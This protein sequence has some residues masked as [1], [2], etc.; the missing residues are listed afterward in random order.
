MTEL[1]PL[2]IVNSIYKGVDPIKVYVVYKGEYKDDD[3]PCKFCGKPLEF[4]GNMNGWVMACSG[5]DW[6][7]GKLVN[8]VGRKMADD[9]YSESRIQFSDADQVAKCGYRCTIL[10]L[11]QELEATKKELVHLSLE[12][13]NAIGNQK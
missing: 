13:L 10:R 11:R 5:T 4:Q 8:E 3:I 2:K 6:V 12:V 1:A 7:D 9:H